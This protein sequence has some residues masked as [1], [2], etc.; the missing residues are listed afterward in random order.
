MRISDWSS[1]VCSSDLNYT[2]VARAL[3]DRGVNCIVQKVAANAEGTQLSL[4]SNTDLTFDAVDA[5]VAAGLPR[6]LLVAEIDPLLPWLG[7]TAAV[8]LDFFDIVV[9]PPAPYPKLFALPRQPVGD[10]EHAIGLY[11]SALVRDGGTLQVG[12]GALS[13]ALR[14]EEHTSELQSLMRI[15][16]AALC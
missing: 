9:A 2:H 16:Y 14:S 1:D 3:V 15:S 11:A 4:S 13:D 6:P 10:A 12:I 8:P 5:I 7:G